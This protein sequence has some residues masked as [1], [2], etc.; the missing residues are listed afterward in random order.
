MERSK[1]RHYSQAPLTRSHLSYEARDQ[2]R[3][4]SSAACSVSAGLFPMSHRAAEM[5]SEDYAP[6]GTD[7]AREEARPW[8][9]ESWQWDDLAYATSAGKA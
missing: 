9:D 4:A 2:S 3:T 5:T 1:G 8:R 7:K 6:V